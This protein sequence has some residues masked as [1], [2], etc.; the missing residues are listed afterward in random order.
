MMFSSN[1]LEREDNNTDIVGAHLNSQRDFF[2][3]LKEE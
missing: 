2:E 3:E 1:S